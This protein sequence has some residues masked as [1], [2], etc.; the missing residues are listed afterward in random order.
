M[1]VKLDLKKAFN[2]YYAGINHTHNENE[3]VYENTLDTTAQTL[4]GAINELSDNQIYILTT[5]TD[6]INRL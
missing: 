2:D 4:S 3:I 1:I 6:Q 5:L